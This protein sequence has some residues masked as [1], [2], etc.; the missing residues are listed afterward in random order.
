MEG[1]FVDTQISSVQ[2][3]QNSVHCETDSMHDTVHQD[4]LSLGW[5]TASYKAETASRSRTVIGF[6]V[7]VRRTMS[8]VISLLSS[9][10]AG[11]G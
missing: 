10:L 2:I 4:T 5:W 8:L 9:L 7:W 11:H 1:F 3:S 6:L